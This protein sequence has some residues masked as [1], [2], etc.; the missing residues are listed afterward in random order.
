MPA[1][2]EV[3]FR[4]RVYSCIDSSGDELIDDAS[5]GLLFRSVLL[6]IDLED[7]GDFWLGFNNFESERE[8]KEGEDTGY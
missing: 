5:L 6:S 1:K 2:I 3:E 4:G 8:G 7:Y